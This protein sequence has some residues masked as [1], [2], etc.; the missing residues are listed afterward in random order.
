MFG[1]IKENVFTVK[2]RGKNDVSIS[3]AKYSCN[4]GSLFNSIVIFPCASLDIFS[5]PKY[6]NIWFYVKKMFLM[7]SIVNYNK[8]NIGK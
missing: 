8:Y 4:F 1:I 7:N 3:T 5:N 2:S 6:L